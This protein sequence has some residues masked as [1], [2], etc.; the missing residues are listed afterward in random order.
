MGTFFPSSLLTESALIVSCT[1]CM[2]YLDRKM[3]QIMLK[4]WL[5]HGNT[6]YIPEIEGLFSL[7]MVNSE[8]KNTD[9]FLLWFKWNLYLLDEN[10][11]LSILFVAEEI[12][13]L[14]TVYGMSCWLG[15]PLFFLQIF[16][17]HLYIIL[18][19]FSWKFSHIF[20]ESPCK[21]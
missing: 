3:W 6:K 17:H 1:F 11:V 2:L 4:I 12:F 7:F 13:A 16:Y 19:T 21:Y 20:S 9:F 10:K 18:K 5:S 8:S 15:R 14:K